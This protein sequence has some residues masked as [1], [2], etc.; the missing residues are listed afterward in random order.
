[1]NFHA[2]KLLY[3]RRQEVPGAE[4]PWQGGCSRPAFIHSFIHSVIQS[5]S[6]SFSYP[7]CGQVLFVWSPCKKAKQSAQEKHFPVFLL[8]NQAKP[9]QPFPAL[10]PAAIPLCPPGAGSAWGGHRGPQSPQQPRNSDKAL[11][12]YWLGSNLGTNV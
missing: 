1:M 5:F 2:L 10:S 12:V 9:N 6:H 8:K 7:R 4:I 3:G 11:G